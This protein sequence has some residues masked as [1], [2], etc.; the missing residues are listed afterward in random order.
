MWI[1]RIAHHACSPAKG[2]RER[3]HI[4][5]VAYMKRRSS[6]D[7]KFCGSPYGNVKADAIKWYD[8]EEYTK[9]F[10]ICE[11]CYEDTFVDGPFEGRFSV[12]S[13]I[14]PEREQ[15]YC[16]NWGESCMTLVLKEDWGRF[17]E[18]V[19]SRIKL[20]H[21]DGEQRTVRE[22]KWWTV[23]GIGPETGFHICETCYSDHFKDSRGE[24]VIEQ[25]GADPHQVLTYGG[26][27]KN[28]MH[29]GIALW[30][31]GSRKLGAEE[32]RRSLFAIA[33][34]PKCGT[35]DGFM[36]GLYYNIRGTLIRHYG[37]CEA[38]YES[39]IAVLELR[40]FFTETP[41][42]VPGQTYS[43]FNP[44]VD[45]C[46][47]FLRQFIDAIQIGVWSGYEDRVRGL[48]SAPSCRGI[49]AMKGGRWWGWPDCTVCQNC[50]HSFAAD[51]ELATDMPLQG[52]TAGP[53]EQ[54]ICG[55][56]SGGQRTRYLEACENGDLLEFLE[57]CRER[58][59]KW[60]ELWPAIQRLQAEI[61]RTQRAAEIATIS[62]HFNRTSDAIT[63]GTPTTQYVTSSGGRYNSYRGVIAER[64]VAEAEA[65]FR[66]SS[67]PRA[68]QARLLAIWG[69][70]E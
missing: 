62:S 39:R 52:A 46:A 3:R 55:L 21:C 68:E 35:Q 42:V 54:H 5:V 27:P 13:N 45:R 29:I 56:F 63:F 34:K 44:A 23:R 57:F 65:L 60:G 43:V 67:N 30:G 16:D 69:M 7:M 64:E 53:E 4:P 49:D 58:Q 12:S 20:G 47:L 36:N 28:N 15:W 61:S 41:K 18:H 66:Q 10:G 31:A 51:T 25:L 32:L 33:S 11:A 1:S 14:E 17:V 38:C 24:Q 48:T 59:V 50:F 19:N 40:P 6:G 9:A 22:T 70:C 26:N 8:S 2:A 37:V